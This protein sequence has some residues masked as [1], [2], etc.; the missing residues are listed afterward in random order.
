MPREYIKWIRTH[1][2]AELHV[3]LP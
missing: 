2:C 1:V 3:Q